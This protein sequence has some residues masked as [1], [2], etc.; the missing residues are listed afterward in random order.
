MSEAEINEGTADTSLPEGLPNAE[1]EIQIEAEPEVENEDDPGMQIG[2]RYEITSKMGKTTGTIYYLNPTSLIRIM[3]DGVSNFLI[4]FPIVETGTDPESGETAYGFDPELGVSEIVEKRKGSGLGFVEWQGYRVDQELQTFKK[5]GSPGPEFKI[6]KVNPET[7]EISVIDSTNAEHVISFNQGQG[8][9]LSEEFVIIR[10]KQAPLPEEMIVDQSD[11]TPPQEEDEFEFDIL[12]EFEVPQVIA[13]V[14]KAATE[15]TYDERTQKSALLDDLRSLLDL[16]SQRNPHLLKRIRTIVELVSS[17]KNSVINYNSN[18][19]PEG[20][21]PISLET[22]QD[23]LKNYKVPLARPILDTKRI[24]ALEATT[25]DDNINAADVA[26]QAE[27]KGLGD[28]VNESETYLDTFV[29]LP[30]SED[31]IGIPQWYQVLTAYF[32]MFPMGDQYSGKGYKFE[33]DGE[34]F[35]YDAPG[36]GIV[37]GLKELGNAAGGVNEILSLFNVIDHSLRRGHGPML[38]GLPKGGT[39]VAIPADKAQIK[40]HLLFPYKATKLGGIG[41]SKTSNLWDIVQKSQENKVWMSKLLKDLGGITTPA[42]KDAQ[43]IIH[44][45]STDSTLVDTSFTDYL[46]LVLDLMTPTG[47]GDLSIFKYE[48]GIEEIEFTVEQQ[49]VIVHRIKQVISSLREKIRAMRE[50][51]NKP[52]EKPATNLL[53]DQ[54]YLEKIQQ[55]LSQNEALG[56]LYKDMAN[57]LPKYKNNDI[58]I[59]SYFFK[60]AQDY[61]MALL[62]GN[63]P[64]IE[65]ER[66]R[67][68]KSNLIS[69]LIA[70]KRFQELKQLSGY[71]PN[72]NP[73]EHVKNLESIRKV[74]NDSDRFALLAK[75]MGIFFG[76][77]DGNW[78]TCQIC[79][80]HLICK[81]EQLQIQQFFHPKEYERIQKE[82]IIGFSGG[83]EGAKLICNTCGLPISNLD[84]DKNIEFDDEGRPMMGRSV[85]VDKDAMEQ[86]KIQNL[87]GITVEQQ[88][89]YRFESDVKNSL[90][91]IL[92]VI[93]DAIYID[94]EGPAIIRILDR[95]E[96][97]M[98]LVISPTAYVQK[99]LP[100]SYAEYL[101]RVKIAIISSLM[102]FEIQSHIPGYVVKNIVE[103]CRPGFGGF[104]LI[105]DAKPED[106]D[107][108]IGVHYVACVVAGIVNT[109][110]PWSNA[111]KKM[112]EEE[113]RKNILNN[114]IGYLNRFLK[115]ISIVEALD[116]K[117][118]YMRETLGASIATKYKERELIPTGFLP[119]PETAKEATENATKGPVIAEGTHGALGEYL[120][121][122]AWIRTANKVMHESG[123][124]KIVK[125]SP[126]TETA[127]CFDPISEPGRFWKEA[128]L[129]EAPKYKPVNPG[130]SLQSILYT[131]ILPRKLQG[132]TATPS[133]DVAYRLLFELCYQGPRKGLPH[134]LGYDNKCDW[135]GL[136]IPE[137]L[138]NPDIDKYGNPIIDELEIRTVLDSKGI[139]LTEQTFQDLLDTTHRISKFSRYIA[140]PPKTPNDI[141]EKIAELDPEPAPGFKANLE[142]TKKNLLTLQDSAVSAEIGRALVPLRSSITRNEGLIANLL[143][144]TSMKYFRAILLESPESIFEILK[145][146]FLVPA[147]RILT[148]YDPKKFLTVPG[149]YKL[150]P[151][152]KTELNTILENHTSFIKDYFLDPEEDEDEDT[153]LKAELKLETFVDQLSQ[154]IKNGKELKISRLQFSSKMTMVQLRMFLIELMRVFV[155][156]PIGSLIDPNVNPDEDE[157]ESV[158]PGKSDSFLENFIVSCMNKYKEEKLVYNP[159]MVK[160]KIVESTEKE[161]Q[162]IIN[163]IDKLPDNLRKLELEKKKNKM[164]DWYIGKAAYSYDPDHWEKHREEIANDYKN[165]ENSSV[166]LPDMIDIAQIDPTGYFDMDRDVGMDYGEGYDYTLHDMD[167]D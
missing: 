88:D 136:E 146:Y 129:P 167:E 149:Q 160:Q 156:G 150:A 87:F 58:G 154:L 140:P 50:D 159:E 95:G 15:K 5:D 92:K 39:E 98:K 123:T 158:D 33:T 80:Q 96:A 51:L 54:T 91:K 32:K 83:R 106:P 7:D 77:M 76:G 133:L 104:P 35:R 55:I 17:L 161:N 141:L 163:R 157:D 119:R 14:E 42:E 48:L 81:H 84:F 85:I 127:C 69:S 25:S 70:D 116:R 24:I 66:I 100:I 52:T 132:F 122:D 153:Y 68:E 152:H 12:G 72:I 155:Y 8:I 16:S 165:A 3:P 59:F 57:F 74:E 30:P 22:L 23:V 90:Y 73:C 131:P 112:S 9:P 120:K 46:R 89:E 19:Y 26:P 64:A 147:Q 126:F 78:T 113:K 34:Y 115:D 166:A 143:D 20:E 109:E 142:L 137:Q 43:K 65:R 13:L 151:T 27:V 125:G 134:E 31:G 130:Y 110:E 75:F 114:M 41:A 99:K 2:D 29:Q 82:I 10:I 4:D 107:K 47:I 139:Q 148:S 44:V 45:S 6:T 61:F 111:Y 118:N 121:A 105:S 49:D 63:Q 128:Q 21:K 135:C 71:Q 40:G 93:S 103:G 60:Y 102:L 37:K 28:L 67:F 56:N 138:L 144:E 62:S 79:N 164:G 124:A 94:L 162:R 36:S 11:L 101:S 108:S 38:Y 1:P 53:L 145:T 86:E 18:G 97:E 117:R